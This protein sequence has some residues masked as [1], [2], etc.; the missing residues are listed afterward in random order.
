MEPDRV[1]RQN[2]V[3]LWNQQLEFRRYRLR[4]GSV[5]RCCK[6]AFVPE[7]ILSMLA[8]IRIFW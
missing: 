7:F 4:Y 5:T 1:C 2:S 3:L 8:V 6:G